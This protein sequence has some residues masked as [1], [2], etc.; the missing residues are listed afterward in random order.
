MKISIDALK[1]VVGCTGNGAVRTLL[2]KHGYHKWND[3]TKI[4]PTF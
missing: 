2:S 1:F 3:L 4:D